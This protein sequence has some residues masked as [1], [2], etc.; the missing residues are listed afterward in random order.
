MSTSYFISCSNIRRSQDGNILWNPFN[1][2]PFSVATTAYLQVGSTNSSSFTVVGIPPKVGCA[3]IQI[4][5]PPTYAGDFS[6]S[7]PVVIALDSSGNPVANL[8]ILLIFGFLEFALNIVAIK[9]ATSGS[10]Y[11]YP[12]FA[13]NYQMSQYSFSGEGITDEQGQLIFE[14]FGLLSGNL[15]QLSFRVLT[16][17]RTGPTGSS[18]IVFVEEN[19]QCTS[20]YIVVPAISPGICELGFPQFLQL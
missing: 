10:K 12:Y 14:N 9:V 7:Q 2:V 15:I 13:S 18:P 11:D 19:A 6:Y 4:V 1:A 8:S 16:L 20:Q 5:T 3:I 17:L